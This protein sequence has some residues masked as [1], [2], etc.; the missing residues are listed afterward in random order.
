MKSAEERQATAGAAAEGKSERTFSENVR[1]LRFMQKSSASRGGAAGGSAGNSQRFFH[2]QQLRLL[3]KQHQ[4]VFDLQQKVQADAKSAQSSQSPHKP[5]EQDAK[6][7]AAATRRL[8]QENR[9]QIE[10][11]K[12]L[13]RHWCAPGWECADELYALQQ[14]EDI[15]MRVQL[16]QPSPEAKCEA[17]ALVVTRRAYGGMNPFV[18]SHMRRVEKKVHQLK[19][20]LEEEKEAKRWQSIHSGRQNVA[21]V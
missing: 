21:A 16:G 2:Q 5:D 15:K 13:R 11:L 7:R 12:E 14:A 8:Q 10:K 3:Q 9:Q 1:R 18:E 4:I 19:R 17:A 20:R 6:A